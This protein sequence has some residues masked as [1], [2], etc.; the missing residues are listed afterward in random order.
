MQRKYKFI[1]Y[2]CVRVS[3]KPKVIYNYISK[4]ISYKQIKNVFSFK[5]VIN[6]S[7]QKLKK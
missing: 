5:K 1:I 7:R 3:L 2:T 6:Y 4:K